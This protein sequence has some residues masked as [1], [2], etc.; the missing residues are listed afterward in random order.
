M[1]TPPRSEAGCERVE[2]SSSREEVAG[3]TVERVAMEDRPSIRRA[4]TADWW[5]VGIRYSVE[6]EG[7]LERICCGGG[8]EAETRRRRIERRRPVGRNI[9][10]DEKWVCERRKK[11]NES[12]ERWC[13]HR[14]KSDGH[15]PAHERIDTDRMRTCSYRGDWTDLR[16][17][18]WEITPYILDWLWSLVAYVQSNF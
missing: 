6:K 14:G 4:S 5:I 8:A 1:G 13:L 17:N 7:G 9:F 18:W 10:E 2:K 11:V 15:G 12:R 16:E 3:K